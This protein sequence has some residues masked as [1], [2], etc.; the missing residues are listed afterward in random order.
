LAGWMLADRL[1]V[2]VGLQLH[3]LLWPTETRGV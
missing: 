3:K 2:R 1:D